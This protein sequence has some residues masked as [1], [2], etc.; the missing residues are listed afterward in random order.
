MQKSDIKSKIFDGIV[1]VF[2]I[3]TLLTV[4]IGLIFLSRTIG[5]AGFIIYIVTAVSVVGICLKSSLNDR[6]S[7]VSR[8]WY[9]IVGGMSAWTVIE[10]GEILGFAGVESKDGFHLFI[11][12]SIF[13]WFL[14]RY[15]PV[16]ARFFI[17]IFFL[18][19]GGHMIIHLQKYLGN[20][21]DIFQTTLLI[22]SWTTIPAGFFI[23]YWIIKKSETR[24]ERLYAAGWL[25]L[26]V[27]TFIHMI[28][29]Y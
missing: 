19:W 10:L 29:F 15:F 1:S 12:A 4:L 14:W 17:F 16:G 7:E 28:F 2:L 6:V 20:L 13:I 26:F 9:G 27:F 18:N 11:L 5:T 21:W 25:Y 24:I 22:Y 8:A 3:V 23:V